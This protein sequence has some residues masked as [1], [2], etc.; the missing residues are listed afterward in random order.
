MPV[1]IGTVNWVEEATDEAACLTPPKLTTLLAA[2]VV[3]NP[4]PVIVVGLPSI[5][6][7]GE[8]DAMVGNGF[9][10]GGKTVTAAGC[11]CPFG[12]VT[13]T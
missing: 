5:P 3:S 4:L 10:N 13:I 9:V 1:G 8:N 7:A 11:D 12:V 2:A 6:L